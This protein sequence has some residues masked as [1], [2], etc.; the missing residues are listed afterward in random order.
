[1]NY[2]A[3]AIRF[4]NQPYFVAGTAM[5]DWIRLLDRARVSSK[6][7]QRF[8]EECSSELSVEQRAICDG[9]LQHHA[10]DDWFHSNSVFMSLNL[11]FAGTL[12]EQLKGHPSNFEANGSMRSHFVAHIA[13]EML[14]DG[15]LIEQ[16]PSRIAEYYR[17]V[18]QLDY[19]TIAATVERIAKRP[20]E[21]LPT[22]IRRF[23]VERFLYDYLDDHRLLRRLNQ[24]M[25]RVSLPQLPEMT[26]EWLGEVRWRTYKH[27][28]ELLWEDT[29]V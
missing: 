1:L 8:I 22:L 21:K 4:L 20:L 19:A 26:T 13:I 24:V 14:L 28:S 2:F 5:P 29:V 6:S 3:H 27:S 17:V 15:H 12:R 18:E 23:A 7:T 10:D 11:E 9:V 25:R 16:E